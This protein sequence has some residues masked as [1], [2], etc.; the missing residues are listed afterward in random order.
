MSSRCTLARQ[1]M[2][3]AFGMSFIKQVWRKAVA[4]TRAHRLQCT[5]ALIPTRLPQMLFVLLCLYGAQFFTG[6]FAAINC[7]P[8]P[9][10]V[11]PMGGAASSDV[12][13]TD[14]AAAK[15]FDACMGKW[16]I[17]YLLYIPLTLGF[18]VYA[19]WRRL[20]MRQ[21]YNIPGDEWEDCASLF[22]CAVPRRLGL[23]RAYVALHRFLLAL[24]RAVCAV[25]GDADAGGQ[26]RRRRA[27]AGAHGQRHGR[28]AA[29]HIRQLEHCEGC[30][31]APHAADGCNT[32]IVS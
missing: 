10:A 24:L 21:R 4:R 18:L 9:V 2:R 3:K 16:N 29:A 19:G 26:Q 11:G 13:S 20:Q 5:G 31:E 1:N 14:V 12:D 23:T 15:Q 7:G 22:F 30:L 27:L 25:P 6:L 28:E 8:P 32:A 17:I